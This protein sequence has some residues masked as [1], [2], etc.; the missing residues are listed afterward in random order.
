M[1]V[2]ADRG[3]SILG[4]HKRISSG[5]HWDGDDFDDKRKKCKRSREGG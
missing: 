5:G 2:F 1:S 3:F 4:D